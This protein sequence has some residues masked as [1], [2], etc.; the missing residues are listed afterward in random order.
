MKLAEFEQLKEA[1]LAQV[2]ALHSTKGKEYAP[3]YDALGHFKEASRESGITPEQAWS[4]LAGKHWR[5]IMRYVKQGEIHSEPIQSRIYDLQLYLLL[6]LGLV[7][8]KQRV[9]TDNMASF[10]YAVSAE[11]ITQ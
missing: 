5:S 2:E 11:D 1:A 10:T 8:E 9:P 4:V 7:E 6:L 3:D